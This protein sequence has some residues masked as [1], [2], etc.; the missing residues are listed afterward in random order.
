MQRDALIEKHLKL[1]AP[2]ALRLKQRLPPS[3]DVEDL[4]GEGMIGLIKAA[5]NYQ[6]NSHGGAP[7]GAYARLKIRGAMVDS[8]RRKCWAENTRNPLEDAPEPATGPRVPYL[9][10][11]GRTIWRAPRLFKPDLLPQPVAL[12][13]RRLTVRQRAILA[14]CYADDEDMKTV[15]QSLQLDL[16]EVTA[17]HEAALRSLRQ[18]AQNVSELCS[19]KIYFDVTDRA[20]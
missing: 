11:K 1:V 13:L 14:A 18:A 9:I 3:F 7:F 16:E 4:I 6:P 2:I 10:K 20:A 17:A 19:T 15:A 5:E 8:V 12:A